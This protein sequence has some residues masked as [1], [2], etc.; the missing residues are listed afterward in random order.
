MQILVPQRANWHKEM[1]KI[2]EVVVMI[3][4]VV[5]DD[6]VVVVGRSKRTEEWIDMF[7]GRVELWIDFC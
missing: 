2:W 3:V 5:V 6:D 4:V 1:P 7:L